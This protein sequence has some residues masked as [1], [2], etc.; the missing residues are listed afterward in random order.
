M[1]GQSVK[2]LRK[3]P[4]TDSV[5]MVTTV[6]IVVLTHDL[7]KGV[8][9]GVIMSALIFGWRSGKIRVATSVQA[10]GAKVYKISG[11]LFFASTAHFTDLFDYQGDPDQIII[12]LAEAHVWDHSGVTALAKVVEPWQ[13]GLHHRAG[14][15]ERATCEPNWSCSSLRALDCVDGCIPENPPGRALPGGCGL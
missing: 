7:A 14:R 13:A 4:L 6:A 3:V 8:M 12:D 2:D 10:A 11:E 9:A 15:G 1:I 5:V